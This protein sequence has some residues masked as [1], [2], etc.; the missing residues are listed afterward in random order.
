MTIFRQLTPAIAAVGAMCAT[1]SQI[2]AA[3]A[4]NRG[5]FAVPCG[6]QIVMAGYTNAAWMQ[7]IRYWGIRD[8]QVIFR[9]AFRGRGEGNARIGQRAFRMPRGGRCYIAFN[10]RHQR[11]PHR[12]YRVRG[13]GR[14]VCAY[15]EDGNDRDFNDAI[16]CASYRRVGGPVIGPRPRPQVGR[17]GARFYVRCGSR[18]QVLGRTNAAWMQ[19]QWI[20]GYAP[21]RTRQFNRLFRGRGEGRTIGRANVAFRN[22]RGWCSIV[23]R[24]ASRNRQPMRAVR[25]R[26]INRGWCVGGEDGGGGASDYNDSVVCFR[27]F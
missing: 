2:D 22:Y 13:G 16:L 9:G 27:R 21:N 25:L 24:M 10:L 1:M 5:R 11:G 20:A 4:Q 18:W 8:N 15:A 6:T 3:D 12:A 17:S 23:V 26:R 14:R 7:Y 19:W